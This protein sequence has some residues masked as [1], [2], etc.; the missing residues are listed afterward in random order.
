[1]VPRTAKDVVSP[2]FPGPRECITEHPLIYPVTFRIMF[3]P[4][5]SFHFGLVHAICF[6]LGR[7]LRHEPCQSQWHR[8]PH[9][10]QSGWSAYYMGAVSGP[11]ALNHRI[12]Q[13]CRPRHRLLCK[14]INGACSSRLGFGCLETYN[15]AI[16][17]LLF[18]PNPMI[19]RYPGL[20]R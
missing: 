13:S 9:S 3:S 6:D 11:N 8:H 17:A 19:W 4:T 15:T 2:V 18:G 10:G 1:M 20:Y 7:A 16:S 14:S 5:F 12:F